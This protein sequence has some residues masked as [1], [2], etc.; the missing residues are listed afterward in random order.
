MKIQKIIK[1]G[2]VGGLIYCGY[3]SCNSLRQKMAEE[4]VRMRNNAKMLLKQTAPEKYDSLIKLG[5]GNST[6]SS[7]VQT[8]MEAEIN[9]L[10]DLNRR[11]NENIAIY[12]LKSV[13]KDSIKVIK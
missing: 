8:W 3:H 13:A 11:M 12:K 9:V 2:I 1:Y 5:I 4:S 10:N 7:D 6:K